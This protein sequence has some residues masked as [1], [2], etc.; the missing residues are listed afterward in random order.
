MGQTDKTWRLD[1]PRKVSRCEECRPGWRFGKFRLVERGFFC[2]TWEDLLHCEVKVLSTFFFFNF[3][4]LDPPVS[5]WLRC[6]EGIWHFPLTA[7]L[8]RSPFPVGGGIRFWP[9]SSGQF[10]LARMYAHL[11]WPHLNLH[12]LALAWHPGCS[13]F[14]YPEVC[15]RCMQ[16]GE[17]QWGRT[18][19]GPCPLFR[20]AGMRKWPGWGK[21]AE[22]ALLGAASSRVISSSGPRVPLL[23]QG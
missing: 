1:S 23:I 13:L 18:Y 19:L 4:I 7:P 6:E 11:R 8:P 9:L 17:T 5:F 20:S 15:R 3:K 16:T 12:F 21:K 2:Y 10:T 22:K 14:C